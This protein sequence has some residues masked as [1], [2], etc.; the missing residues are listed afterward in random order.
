MESGANADS[1]PPRFHFPGLVTRLWLAGTT[2]VM[3]ATD[4]DSLISGHLASRVA[5]GDAGAFRE[6]FELM[7]D[8]LVRFATRFVDEA[9][10]KDAVQEAFV[11]IW[12][13]RETIDAG[14]S[15]R[16]LLFR[17]VRNLAFNA[18]RDAD[19]RDRLLAEEAP[20]LLAGTPP[21]NPEEHMEAQEM[22]ALLRKSIDALPERQR[23][24]LVLSRFSGL[25]HQ[26]IA[27]VMNVSARTVNN[28]LVRALET[29]RTRL[30]QAGALSHG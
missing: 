19:T 5:T 21:M 2:A 29:L 9:A 17:T 27:E 11:R 25:S 24:A 26:E 14:Q 7:H 18:V 15:L 8:Q 13:K 23:E 4:P 3:S 30:Q 20:G 22:G 10:A 6:L 1:A 12:R 28:H 16:A